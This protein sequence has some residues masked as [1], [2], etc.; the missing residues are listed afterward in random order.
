MSMEWQA[1]KALFQIQIK[2]GYAERTNPEWLN[3]AN[4]LQLFAH[5]NEVHSTR[6]Y[7]CDLTIPRKAS[8]LRFYSLKGIMKTVL[9][10]FLLHIVVFLKADMDFAR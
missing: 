9:L 6:H 5:K 7:Q 1:A 10:I 3:N 8:L 4:Y 2:T